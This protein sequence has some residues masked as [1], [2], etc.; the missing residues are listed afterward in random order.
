MSSF[1]IITLASLGFSI[2]VLAKVLWSFKDGK[3][4]RE[5][6][7]QT[8]K[9]AGWL[10]VGFF[11]LFTIRGYNEYTQLNVLEQPLVLPLASGVVA[12]I[13]F[14][15]LSRVGACELY[16]GDHLL[17][18]NAFTNVEEIKQYCAIEHYC[19]TS[20]IPY[21]GAQIRECMTAQNYLL[22]SILGLLQT[23]FFW[24]FIILIGLDLLFDTF[25]VFT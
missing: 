18:M 6:F 7:R 4:T 10:A 20:H 22:A 24:L 8:V 15:T 17:S 23:G 13:P 14:T 2:I 19:K 25:S 3:L 11:L 1:D 12:E 21:S 16:W 5:E 9:L